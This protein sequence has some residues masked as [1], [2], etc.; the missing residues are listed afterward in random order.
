MT[1]S[2][3]QESELLL[4]GFIIIIILIVPFLCQNAVGLDGA[5]DL[6][7]FPNVLVLSAGGLGLLCNSSAFPPSALSKSCMP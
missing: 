6:K 7:A 2:P 1:I 5:I 4:R 3:N